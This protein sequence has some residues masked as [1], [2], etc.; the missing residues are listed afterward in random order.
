M[1]DSNFN[2]KLGDFGLARI[3]DHVKGSQ[4][5][6]LASTMGYMAPECI[7]TSNASK[8]SDVYS[9]E[10]VALEIACGRKSIKPNAPQDQVVM[11]ERVW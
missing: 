10:I 4:T 7:T 9:F 1:L 11:V 6:V 8:K 5:T 3:V 2:A